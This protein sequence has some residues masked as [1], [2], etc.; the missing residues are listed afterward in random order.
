VIPVAVAHGEGRVEMDD[1]GSLDELA[2]AVQFVDG[3]HRPT[4]R[5]PFNPNGSVKGIAGLTSTDGRTLIMMPHPERVFRTI[6]NS[7]HPD[8]WRE[9][10]PWLRLFRNARVALRCAEAV[11][12]GSDWASHA[13]P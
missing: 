2:I 6:A 8:D 9:D 7:W 4:E 5:Y 10:G 11:T 12:K 1:G 3:R 13:P